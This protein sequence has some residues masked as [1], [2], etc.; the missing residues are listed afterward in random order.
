MKL[1]SQENEHVN[2]NNFLDSIPSYHIVS[3]P[4]QIEVM[5][6]QRLNPLES[7]SK[8]PNQVIIR[9]IVIAAS[10]GDFD[11]TEHNILLR[12]LASVFVT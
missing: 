7:I 3:Y 6:R 10:H 11:K 8:T 12:I 9:N 5:F 4:Y 2:E 1:S